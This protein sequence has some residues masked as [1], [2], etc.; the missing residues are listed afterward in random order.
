MYDQS[1][2]L[3]GQTVGS[4]TLVTDAGSSCECTRDH[5]AEETFDPTTA[6]S[7]QTHYVGHY[8]K[9]AK[10]MKQ[11]F[12]HYPVYVKHN[13]IITRRKQVSLTINTVLIFRISYKCIILYHHSLLCQ[14]FTWE[15]E[16]TKGCWNS[17]N[18]GFYK[19]PNALKRLKQEIF[20]AY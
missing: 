9:T 17:T 10:M 6:G 16:K 2:L 18:P 13:N 3:V 15:Q 11:S 12:R 8:G 5:P 7:S 19:H 20:V 14:Y 4:V 1:P